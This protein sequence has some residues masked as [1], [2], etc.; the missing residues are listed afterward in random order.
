MSFCT[1]C[2]LSTHCHNLTVSQ[3]MTAELL[4][5][6]INKKQLTAFAEAQFLNLPQLP[7]DQ[8]KIRYRGRR[9][10]YDRDDPDAV[11]GI[12]EFAPGVEDEDDL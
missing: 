6:L 4:K 1:L 3:V 8:R 12:N 2:D 10:E 11:Q 5:K 9:K 7:P